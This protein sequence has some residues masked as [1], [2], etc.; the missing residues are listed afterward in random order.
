M[1]RISVILKKEFLQIFRNKA[2]IPIIF[3]MPF[4]QLLVLAFAVTYEI[5]NINLGVLDQDLSSTSRGIISKFEGS[6]FFKVKQ[7]SFDE[8]NLKDELAAGNIDLYLH[9]PPNFE[10]DL[11]K[12]QETSINLQLDAINGSK[13]GVAQNYAMSI[14]SDYNNDFRTHIAVIPEAMKPGNINIIPAFW[15]NPELDYQTFMVPGI[16]VI[17]VTMIGAFL[18]GMNIVK[19]K[20]QGTI[21]QLNVTPIKKYQFIVGKLLPFWFI[22]MFEL[23]LGLTLGV[24]IFNIPILGNLGLLFGFTAIYLIL[25]LG[26]GLLVST[27]TDTQQQAMFI[28]WFFLVIFILMSG[29]FTPIESMPDWAQQITH[30]N[31]IK[32][33]VEVIR[34]VL[35]KGSGWMETQ[36]HFLIIFGFAIGLNGL[37]IMN[38]RKRTS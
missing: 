18:S 23:A 33:F 26:F 29:L 21:E 25:I 3:F 15:Y 7:F 34:M 2:M 16:L 1:R 9:F 20:E 14:I 31:P 19:E 5:K 17:L 27:F 28:S 22:G 32:Y 12:D 6:P 4:V 38:Y 35:L 36:Q 11:Y 37:A 24:L 8:Q 30:F 13:A 10:K